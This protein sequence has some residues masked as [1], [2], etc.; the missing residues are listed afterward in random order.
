VDWAAAGQFKWPGSPPISR[1]EQTSHTTWCTA[2]SPYNLLVAGGRLTL[3]WTHASPSLSSVIKAF[4]PS[5]KTPP[6]FLHFFPHRRSPATATHHRCVRVP[7]APFSI[8]SALWI[9]EVSRCVCPCFCSSSPTPSSPT[10][11]LATVFCQP[12]VS[13]FLHASH[14]RLGCAWH[15]KCSCVARKSV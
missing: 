2:P 5:G 4:D 10:P 3:L 15:P 8:P 9:T 11:D 13:S 14:R 1:P 12:P 7:A 6:S